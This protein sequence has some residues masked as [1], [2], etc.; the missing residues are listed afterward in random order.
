EYQNI[1]FNGYV[2]SIVGANAMPAFTG[3][4]PNVNPAISTEFSTVGFRFGHSLLS[5]TFGRDQNNG[6]PIPDA[7][8]LPGSG[9]P[10][11]LTEDFFR[12][13]LLNNNHVVVNLVDRFGN[14][15]PHTSSTIS[16]VLKAMADGLPNDFDL[17][18]I[19]EVRNILFG[20][21][22]GPGTDLAA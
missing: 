12:P 7:P 5:S 20:I 14:P 8:G 11:N 3:Y 4:N 10:V 6:T 1:V 15:D 13:D 9:G 18:L 17:K 2:P 21:P 19:D 16:E 22:N